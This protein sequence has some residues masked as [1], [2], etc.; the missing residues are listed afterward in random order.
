MKNV[1]YFSILF[2]IPFFYSFNINCINEELIAESV[3]KLI[4]YDSWFDQPT[5]SIKVDSGLF[6]DRKPGSLEIVFFESLQP[7]G[8][9]HLLAEQKYQQAK[10]I[11]ENNTLPEKINKH[12]IEICVNRIYTLFDRNLLIYLTCQKVS[13]DHLVTRYYYIEI[14]ESEEL[15]L[16]L[17]ENLVSANKLKF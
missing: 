13:G 14:N 4:A 17:Y 10:L 6:V 7:N 2:F 3:E 15:G 5:N 12:G 9:V 11:Y 8:T 16:V 1:F